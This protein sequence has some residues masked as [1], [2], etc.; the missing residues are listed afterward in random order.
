MSEFEN[1][2]NTSKPA[3]TTQR[4][5][6]LAMA[7]PLPEDGRGYR[8][9]GPTSTQTKTTAADSTQSKVPA[10]QKA[11]L[12]HALFC[13]G[14]LRQGLIILSKFPWL[15][16]AH[17]DIADALLR[18][19]S[20]SFEPLYAPVSLAQRSPNYAASNATARGKWTNAKTIVP[21]TRAQQ[22]TLAVPVPPPTSSNFFTF[23]YPRWHEWV[24]RLRSHS[25]L[26]AIGVPLL[27]HVGLLVHRDA[28]LLT[29]LCR[30]GKAQLDASVDTVS[31]DS[32]LKDRLMTSKSC[33]RLSLPTLML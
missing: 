33:R 10:N 20:V 23:F 17:S 28:A 4:S 31:N 3:A 15:T 7:A 11:R 1:K 24:P 13:I 30:I 22:L 32:V 27:R 29:R 26:M 9:Q 8:H 2:W 5:N 21:L 19:L 25:Q 18:L 6:A 14:A 16:S 12:V